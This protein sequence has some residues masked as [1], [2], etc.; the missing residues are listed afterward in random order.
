MFEV[1]RSTR[2][3]WRRWK[4]SPN[5]NLLFNCNRWVLLIC[6]V[7]FLKILWIVFSLPLKLFAIRSSRDGLCRVLASDRACEVDMFREVQLRCIKRKP[8]YK[9][10][11]E[12]LPWTT[13]RFHNGLSRLEQEYSYDFPTWC[14]LCLNYQI[15]LT[16]LSGD[17]QDNLMQGVWS[18]PSLI[19]T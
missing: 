19:C 12:K 4:R 8:G 9:V 6:T 2:I 17:V 14:L 5:I 3:S 16:L 1:P 15:D 13:I 10:L 11:E 7:N 18:R